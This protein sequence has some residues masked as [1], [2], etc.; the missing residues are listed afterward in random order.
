MTSG[1]EHLS[2][3][4][5]VAQPIYTEEFG[6]TVVLS[7]HPDDE[8]LGCG[9]TMALLQQMDIPVQVVMVS[10]GSQ[11]HPNSQKYPANKLRDLRE[12]ETDAALH[13]LGLSPEQVTFFRLPDGNVPDNPE[14]M[15]FQDAVGRLVAELNRYQ[16]QTILVPWR[17]DP[18]R[19]HRATWQLLQSAMSGLKTQ[20]RVLEYPIWLWELGSPNDAPHPDEI[21]AVQ[22]D[23]TAVHDQKHRAIAAH[24][25]QVTQLI[26]DDPEAFWLRPD[27]LVYFEGN[28]ELFFERS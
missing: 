11:S 2:N 28:S 17:R 21:R 13:Q 27:L 6:S 23:I 1:I 4:Q 7:P 22:V 3:W 26:D 19:D 16:P 12:S 24:A 8:S 10:D 20:A 25:S 14:S 9:G 15:R 18:H 5:L